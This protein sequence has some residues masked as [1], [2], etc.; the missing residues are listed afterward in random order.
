L[1]E[2][3]QCSTWPLTFPLLKWTHSAPNITQNNWLQNCTGQA[4]YQ[5]FILRTSAPTIPYPVCS[6]AGR[7]LPSW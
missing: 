4:S 7:T 1:F 6:I 2:I 5:D 3:M